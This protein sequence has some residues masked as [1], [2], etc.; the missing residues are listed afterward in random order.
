MASFPHSFP[1]PFVSPTEVVGETSVKY[2]VYLN[3]RGYVLDTREDAEWVHRSIPLLKPQQDSNNTTAEASLNPDSLWRRAQESW[4]GG[5]GQTFR[6]RDGGDPTRFR[7]SQGVDPWTFWEL[8]LLNDTTLTLSSSEANLFFATTSTHFYAT[9]GQSTRIST[10]LSS[11]STL[12]GTPAETATGIASDGYNVWIAYGT[13]GVYATTAGDSSASSYVTGT[14]DKIAYVKGRL[15][16]SAGPAIYNVTGAGALPTAL[17]TQSNSDFAWVGFAE[18][19]ANIYAA[20][21]SGDKSLIYRIAVKPDAAALDQPIVAGRLPDGEVVTAIGGYLGFIVLGTTLGVRFCTV[22]AQGNL[23]IGAVFGGTEPLC[24]EGQGT[25][26]WF[27]WTNYVSGSTGLGRLDLRT[28]T[29]N[30]ITGA[31]VPAYATDLMADGTGAVVS[32]ATFS[33][34]RVFA[35][36]GLGIYQEDVNTKVDQGTLDTGETFFGISEAKILLNVEVNTNP[37]HGSYDVAAAIDSGT[38]AF[39][40]SQSSV[41][42]TSQEF[43]VED[44]DGRRFELRFTLNRDEDD[45]DLGPTLTRWSMK[46]TPGGTDSPA[47]FVFWPI[48]LFTEVKLPNGAPIRVDIATERDELKQLRRSRQVVTAVEADETFLAQVENYAWNPEHF[49]DPA[50]GTVIAPSGVMNIQ[51][52]RLS[53]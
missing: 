1:V 7:S 47:E 50:E 5:A 41:G 35:V 30:T 18:G 51:L 39:L 29:E 21:W 28:F 3:G 9:D 52:K 14:V 17:F 16:V 6:D 25:F 36:A 26:I 33:E 37:L 19:E 12:T 38:F 2:P 46:A 22:D 48:M 32:T 15:M 13:N 43:D 4:H 11:Y 49:N 31:R 42:S 53:D 20:G 40:G 45:A 8:S 10:D 34:K 23:N 27:G 24:F 44:G